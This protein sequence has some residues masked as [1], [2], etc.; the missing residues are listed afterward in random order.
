MNLQSI[1]SVAAV[2]VMTNIGLFGVSNGQTCTSL[3]T[4][5][6]CTADTTCAWDP[7]SSMCGCASTMPQDIIFI[8]DSSGSVGSANYEIEKTFVNNLIDTGVS[9]DSNIA[10]LSFSNTVTTDYSFTEPQNDGRVGVTAAVTGSLFI[11]STTATLDVMNAALT[12][13]QTNGVN[14]GIIFLITDGQ[15]VPSFTQTVCPDTTIIKDDLDAEDLTVVIIAVGTF[16]EATISCLVDDPTT[17][18]IEVADFDDDDFA[19]I[20]ALTDGF[21]CPDLGTDAPTEEP[22]PK[23][24]SLT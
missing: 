9:T 24:I 18:I 17:Q 8:M 19:S 4:E 13:Y 14:K 16:N 23:P 2:G 10:V 21:L 22:T 11:G 3:T 7:V 20:R 15:P 5:A 1:V 12:E 6:D